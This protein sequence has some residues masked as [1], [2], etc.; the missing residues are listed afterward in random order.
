MFSKIAIQQYLTKRKQQ[1]N[2]KYYL[3]A[4]RN[5]PHPYLIYIPEPKNRNNEP[6]DIYTI[7]SGAFCQL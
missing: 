7:H 5:L 3:F 1:Y 2:Q 6:G 4:S